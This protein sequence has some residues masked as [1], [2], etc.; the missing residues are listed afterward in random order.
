[1]PDRQQW[2]ARVKRLTKDAC[3]L[4]ADVERQI[5]ERFGEISPAH[6]GLLDNLREVE[7]LRLAAAEDVAENGLRERYSNGRQTLERKNPAVDILLKASATQAKV[8]MTM[9]LSKK[10][11]GK[12]GPSDEPPEDGDLD[13]LDNY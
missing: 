5:M 12:S 7:A 3:M 13:D 9:G 10:Q 2:L 4:C 6:R 11:R 8:V 1:M